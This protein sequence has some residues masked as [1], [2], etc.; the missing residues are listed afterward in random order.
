MIKSIFKEIR[1]FIRHFLILIIFVLVFLGFFIL[2][3]F[4]CAEKEKHNLDY[5]YTSPNN[6]RVYGEQR[7][8]DYAD[9]LTDEQETALEAYIREAE[10]TTVSDIVIVTLNESLAAFADEYKPLDVS[11][12]EPDKYTMIYA[13]EF[14]EQNKF[15]YDSAQVLDGTTAT[16]DGVILVD[17]IFREPE[18]DKIYTWMG[19]TGICEDRFSSYMID[20]CLD[21]F[22]ALVETDYYQACINYI[23]KFVFWMAPYQTHPPKFFH[24]VPLIVA[25]IIFLAYFFTKRVYGVPGPATT[26]STYLVGDPT[27]EMIKEDKLLNKDVSRS[28]HVSYSSGS[29]S[30]HSGGGGHHTSRSGGSHGGGGRSR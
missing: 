3:Y 11:K 10:K 7:V 12:V 6:E 20:T 23:D 4:K 17:N 13:D 14:W 29:G 19:T 2:R 5:M 25:V 27:I 24:I 8:F 30:S 21:E 16:G 28:V 26:Y 18:T 9:M 22:Y 15:G 1:R